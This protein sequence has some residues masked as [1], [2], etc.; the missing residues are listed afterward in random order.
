[1][2]DPNDNQPRNAIGMMLFYFGLVYFMQGLGQASG[3]VS[4][5]LNFFFKE[6]LGLN[7]AQVTEYLA[8]LTFPWIIK[9]IYGIISDFFPLLG[10]RRKTWL[11]AMNGLA[12]GGFLWLT[13]L[14][15]PSAIVSAM[16]LT[17]FGTAASDVIV[18]AIMVE[19]GNALNATG[20]FQGVQWFWFYLAAIG[21]SLAGG[22]LCSLFA[23]SKALSIAAMITFFAPLTV[24]VASWLMVKEEK[25]KVN[26]AGFKDT[27]VN[28]LMKINKYLLGAAGLGIVAAVFY[29]GTVAIWAAPFVIALFAFR[30]KVLWMVALFIA[31]FN[32]SPSFGT[33]FYYHMTDTL[34]FSQDFIGQLGAWSSAGSVLGSLLFAKYFAKQSTRFN[35]TFSII[36]GVIGTLAYLMLIAPSANAW[37]I[38]ISLNLVFGVCSMVAVLSVLTLAAKAC[39]EKSEGFTFAALMSVYNAAAQVSA[40]VGARLYVDVFANSMVPLIY[41]SAAFTFACIFLLPLLKGVKENTGNGNDDNKDGK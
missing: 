23:P 16:L 10:Y 40:I 19:K 33:P 14:D 24:M 18:D 2:R 17:A 41:V 34:K 5:P 21:T 12:A 8:I 3:L 1:M 29:F 27:F 6:A 30:S 15:T 26:I 22:Y 32:F 39:P 9:P 7:P 25:S 36:T 38:A 37:L 28:P 20:R 35:L 13:G 31:F 11:L 4:Q